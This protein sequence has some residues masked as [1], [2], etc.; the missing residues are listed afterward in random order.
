MKIL[1]SDGGKTPENKTCECPI[2][3][4]TR[5]HGQPEMGGSST[6]QGLGL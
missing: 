1:D 6:A 2:P 5:G 3:G 4:G